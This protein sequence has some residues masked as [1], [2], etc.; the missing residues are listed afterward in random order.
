M[1]NRPS[2][3]ASTSSV[4]VDDTLSQ[5][6]SSS[7]FISTTR[8]ILKCDDKAYALPSKSHAGLYSTSTSLLATKDSK[9]SNSSSAKDGVPG[10][11]DFPSSWCG[12][13]GFVV[14]TRIPAGE[15][16]SQQ[17]NKNHRRIVR[18]AVNAAGISLPRAASS[19]HDKA[20]KQAV[21]AGKQAAKAVRKAKKVIK[22]KKTLQKRHQKQQMKALSRGLASLSCA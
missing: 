13:E 11:P 17:A 7:L 8:E 3:T 10:F 2:L 16:R 4:V 21:K 9:W 18:Q 5:L 20:D 12:E 1:A 22:R 14:W 19:N 15:K 6:A